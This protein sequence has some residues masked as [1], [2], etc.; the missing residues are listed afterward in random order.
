M[1]GWRTTA[2]MDVSDDST[3]DVTGRHRLHTAFIDD[4]LVLGG[5]ARENRWRPRR[6]PHT[7]RWSTARVERIK[8]A[9]VQSGCAQIIHGGTREIS[10]DEV[11]KIKTK[12]QQWSC[13]A[14]GDSLS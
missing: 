3:T 13:I 1:D 4:V 12:R 8:D 10:R 14:N 5:R 6:R 11:A 7:R 9:V 2:T